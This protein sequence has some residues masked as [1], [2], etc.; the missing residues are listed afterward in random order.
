M[1]GL[2]H[3][4]GS[5]EPPLIETTIGEALAQAA[6][7]RPDEE[8]LVSRHQ[9]VRLTWR[10]LLEQSDALAAGLLSLGLEPGDRVGVWA[11]N[12]A[13]WAIVQFATARA[14]MIQVNINPA[15]RLS[16]LEYTLTKVGVRALICAARFKTSDYA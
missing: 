14:G 6:A 3:V 8:A 12:C 5:T 9:G 15:Y 13:E 7:A 2:S 4:K 11:P 10:E 1:D 16:E